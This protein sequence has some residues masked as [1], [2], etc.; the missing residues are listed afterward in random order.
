MSEAGKEANHEARKGMR[1]WIQSEAG[2]KG[3]LEVST[4]ARKYITNGRQNELQRTKRH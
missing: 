3:R 4:Y 1:L 2:M